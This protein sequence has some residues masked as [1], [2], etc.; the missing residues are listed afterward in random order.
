V[1]KVHCTLIRPFRPCPQSYQPISFL[2]KDIYSTLMN[3]RASRTLK[4]RTHRRQCNI[5]SSYSMM[6]EKDFASS[7]L[8]YEAPLP[9]KVFV[10]RW[11]NNFVDSESGAYRVLKFCSIWSPTQPNTPFP[12]H[13][14]DIV[15]SHVGRV[16]NYT[17]VSF[18][19]RK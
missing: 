8:F 10:L 19:R 16:L 7:C 11:S 2:H 12:R 6:L 9:S 14:L 17:G 15:S 1:C 3:A 4:D 5:S 13:T 18:N